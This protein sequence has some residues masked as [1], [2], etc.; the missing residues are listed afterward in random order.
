[1]YFSI[2][3]GYWSLCCRFD[4]K[5]KSKSYIKAI[6]EAKKD[7]VLNAQFQDDSD[8]DEDEANTVGGEN[9][10]SIG[11]TN[12][13]IVEAKEDGPC[14][15]SVEES[16]DSKSLLVDAFLRTSEQ[17]APS[18]QMA[19]T[20]SEANELYEATNNANDGEEADDCLTISLPSP[21]SLL[22][23]H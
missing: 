21:R 3:L 8:P 6:N 15:K 1:L 16:K 11:Q 10:S 9:L 19:A 14:E 17:A 5:K 12:E 4:K 18:N 13:S 2:I 22:N 23:S 7:A 20:C